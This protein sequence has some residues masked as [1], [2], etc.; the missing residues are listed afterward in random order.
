[1]RS[2]RL[3]DAVALGG[4][5]VTRARFAVRML[6]ERWELPPRSL[7][8]VTHRSDWDIPLTTN[9][10]WSGGM[11]GR[12]PRLVFVARDDMFLPGFLA[13]YPRRLPLSVRRALTRVD[14]GGALRAH[15][16]ALPIASASRAQLAHVAREEPSLPLET[17]PETAEAAR[18]RARRLGL[19][20][21]RTLGDLLDAAYLD[22][23]W[24]R[25]RTRGEL[26]AADAFWTRRQ[27]L[28]R[29]DFEGLL[30]HVASGGTLAIYPEGHPSPDGAIGPLERGLSVLVR[31]A[32]P[33]LLIPVGLAY[34]PLARGRTRAYV[35][36][37]DPIAAA[38]RETE[39]RVLAALRRTL[40]LTPGQ[41]AA[42][43]VLHGLDPRRVAGEALQEQRPRE[44][45][46]AALL[47]E[48]LAAAGRAPRALLERLDLEFR[49]ARAAE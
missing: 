25:W 24:P 18:R 26:P 42:H 2:P 34:D 37:G 19:R 3:F 17:L 28:A 31:R 1:M 41:V 12:D 8:L 13:G 4:T 39:A 35:A 21:P 46:L 40:P 6:N 48:A 30:E 33:D 38:P 27:A 16:L 45:R 7:L 23:L 36:V 47:D 10:Y 49:S 29:R 9:V 32:R 43:A 20:E 44:P 14:V 15:G 5:A 22:L 11:W